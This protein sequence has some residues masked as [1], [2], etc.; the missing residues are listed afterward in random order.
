M[1]DTPDIQFKKITDIKKH[2]ELCRDFYIG[3]IKVFNE[4]YLPK[5]SGETDE[6]YAT[7]IASTAF[8]NMYAPI[9]DG[10]AGLI[11]KTEPT[12]EKLDN[13]D[14]DNVDLKHHNIVGFGKEVIKKS[15]SEGIVFVSVET[16]TQKNRAFFKMYSYENLMSY[17]FE[18]D[19]LV[20]IVFRDETEQQDG[21]FGVKKLE[22]YIVFKRGGG[23]VWYKGDGSDEITLQ[24]EWFNN[25]Q[26]IPVVWFTTG[27]ELSQFEII[28]KMYDIANLNRVH[29]NL[30]SNIANV[31]S[32][33]GNPVPI[34]YGQVE[35][36]KITIGVKDALRF[37]DKQ[38][39]GFE[40]GEITG[41]GVT[42]LQNKIKL[43]EEQI[44]KTTFSILKKETNKTV[45]DAQE[46]R[47]KNTSFL[48]DV[49][50]ELET[51]MN[52]LIKYMAELENKSLKDGAFIRYKKDF[53]EEIINLEIA[54]KLLFAGEMSRETFYTI[55]KTGE[56]PKDFDVSKETEKI[57]A[58]TK[59]GASLG[60]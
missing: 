35:E 7:R 55:L 44:D 47:N 41:A 50:T 24:Y 37:D 10:L 28:P 11:T 16:N 51:K 49:A 59:S 26:D 53:D 17:V 52:I 5:W 2:I 57:E 54:E 46:S 4:T 42:H 8:A 25:L 48:T 27:K 38:K 45:I 3:S 32:V 1:A 15:L 9:I 21:R 30:E 18:D 22:R 60:V 34:F 29:L 13:L 23:E 6:G 20:Q 56:L 19:V 36:D 14:L 33:V 39:E 31:L 58:E 43:I 12:K 40:Y